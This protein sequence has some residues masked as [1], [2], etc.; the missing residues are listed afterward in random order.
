MLASV[1]AS[2]IGLASGALGS[3]RNIGTAI[4][5]ELLGSVYTVSVGDH[6]SGTVP[7]IVRVAAEQFRILPEAIGH[8]A[9]T[10]AIMQGFIAL[11]L[12]AALCCGLAVLA[13]L[14]AQVKVITLS[15]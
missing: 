1:P 14:A 2:Q 10:S 12:A 7:K 8:G 15:Q 13:M 4:G 5:V 11:N 3:A 6:F 9:V